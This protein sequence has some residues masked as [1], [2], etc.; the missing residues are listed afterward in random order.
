MSNPAERQ[1]HKGSDPHQ[2][3]CPQ[4]EATAH[5]KKVLSD[6]KLDLPEADKLLASSNGKT[7]SRP[8][9]TRTQTVDLDSRSGPKQ[10]FT[11]D[12]LQPMLHLMSPCAD[13]S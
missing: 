13:S 5:A 6:S 8:Q 4:A 1:R 10:V 7:P 2:A 3:V 12:Q 9:P 11:A